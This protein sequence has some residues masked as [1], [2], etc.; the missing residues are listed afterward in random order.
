[1]TDDTRSRQELVDELNA[2]RRENEILKQTVSTRP[3]D[4]KTDSKKDISQ[5]ILVVDDNE[6]T[7][8]LVTSM[9]KT[10]G[11]AALAA[12]SA[13]EAIDRFIKSGQKIDLIISDIVMPEEDGP[14]MI[15]HILKIRPNIKVIFMSG[16][17]ED[18]I[19]HD[20]VYKIRDSSAAFM[21][22]PF[23]LSELKSLLV[24]QMNN[25]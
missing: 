18:E 21:K 24:K 13:S 20:S 15:D 8:A 3:E 19:I 22:K 14:G 23:S 17:E 10:L 6:D 1:M 16:Y 25:E 4:A 9:V 2:L 5:T 12:A 11:Y 7:R